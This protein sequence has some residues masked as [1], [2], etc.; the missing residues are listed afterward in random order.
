V[1]SHSFKFA[2]KLQEHQGC[3]NPILIRIEGRAGHGAGTPKNKIINQVAE[4]Y[5]YALSV[6]D[7]G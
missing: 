7:K 4:V 3:G 5:G 1:P 2:A 6:I